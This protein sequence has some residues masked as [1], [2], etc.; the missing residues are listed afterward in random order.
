M[1]PEKAGSRSER[2]LRTS[3]GHGIQ[4]NNNNNNNNNFI[5]IIIYF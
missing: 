5:L 4:N 3:D 1:I 2:F